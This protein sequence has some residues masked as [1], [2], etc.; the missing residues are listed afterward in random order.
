MRTNVFVDISFDRVGHRRR[1][2]AWLEQLAAHPD[3]RLLPVFEHKPLMSQ[4][5]AGEL[6]LAW[7][8]QGALAEFLAQGLIVLLGR[9]GE[10]GL[11]AIDVGGIA[12]QAGPGFVEETLADGHPLTAHGS[13]VDLRTVG[14]MLAPREAHLAAYARGLTWWHARHGFC[15]VCGAPTVSRD[16]GHRRSC[17]N[18]NCGVDHFP[19][20]DPAV[21]MLIHRGDKVLLARQGV[22]PPGMHSVLAGF[23][24]PGESLEATVH[25]E[26]DEETGVQVRDVRYHSSQ[27]W[28]FPQS[29]MLGFTA[30]AVTEEIT[31]HDGELEAAGWFTR[32]ELKSLPEAELGSGDF[33]LPRKSSIAR[34]L[35]DEWLAQG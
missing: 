35:V 11:F 23:V 18:P 26:V 25:R 29:L 14:T 17:T 19:R 21:I 9:D 10:A 13:F 34:R 32:S 15:G 12:S 8:P 33:T 28:P 1:D 4:A 24:E 27:P 7:L 2:E 31:L 30:E 22:W 16:A 3:S 6:S 5:G 20:S